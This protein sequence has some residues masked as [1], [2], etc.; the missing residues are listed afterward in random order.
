MRLIKEFNLFVSY[1]AKPS[2]DS[3]V[4]ITKAS[5]FFSTGF[6]C[7]ISLDPFLSLFLQSQ[8]EE[9]DDDDDWNPCKAAGVCLM[10]MATCC[11]NDVIGHVLPF[12]QNNIVSTDWKLRDAAA[13][14]FGERIIRFPTLSY[15]A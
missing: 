1:L 5:V 2:C 6:F 10:L 9:F 12:V 4:L 8:Q 15:D 3:F 11:E 7:F 14:A 13:M